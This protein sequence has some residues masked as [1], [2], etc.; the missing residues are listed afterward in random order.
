MPTAA[1]F[2]L[3][4]VK[5]SQ[6]KITIKR[7]SLDSQNVGCGFVEFAGN[8]IR[9]T[10]NVAGRYLITRTVDSLTRQKIRRSFI[11]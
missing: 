5:Q 4:T 1:Q 9:D 3:I 2:A 6:P 11:A 8:V 10:V 7:N